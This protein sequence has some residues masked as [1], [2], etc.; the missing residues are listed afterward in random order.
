M[1]A[2]KKSVGSKVGK[3]I[4]STR[5]AKRIERRLNQVSQKDLKQALKNKGLGEIKNED[6]AKAMSGKQRAGWSPYKMRRVVE[7]LQ[8][9]GVARKAR[10]ASQMVTQASRDAQSDMKDRMQKLA[11]DRRKEANAEPETTSES[12]LGILDR[13][14][15]AMGRANKA[16]TGVSSSGVK[17]SNGNKPKANPFGRKNIKLQPKLKLPKE[18]E[19][20]NNQNPYIGFQA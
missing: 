12:A 3:M 15:G 13:M 4:F 18:N 8:D 7:A 10:T 9:V 6:I 20:K 5:S 16:G 17:A 11:R 1:R 2:S 14:R 19:D